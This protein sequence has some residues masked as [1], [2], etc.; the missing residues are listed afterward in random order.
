MKKRRRMAFIP[1]SAG[2]MADECFICHEQPGEP[3]VLRNGVRLACDS[4]EVPQSVMNVE[5]PERGAVLSGLRHRN[6][7]YRH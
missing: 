7:R 5:E 3:I 6:N 4:C 2:T 1:I